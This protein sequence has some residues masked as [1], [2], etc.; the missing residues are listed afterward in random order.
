M[1]SISDHVFV[2]P[3]P[4]QA[5][6]LATYKNRF[7]H[8]VWVHYNWSPK[9]SDDGQGRGH[10]CAVYSFGSKYLGPNLIHDILA[11]SW[12]EGTVLWTHREQ[13]QF[14]CVYVLGPTPEEHRLIAPQAPQGPSPVLR[15]AA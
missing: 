6:R 1:E 4:P 13:D 15:A 14:P 8:L 11:E 2:I 9:C 7:E 10:D 5:G 12:P 3:R